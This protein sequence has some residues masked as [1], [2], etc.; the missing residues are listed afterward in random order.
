VP[1][2]PDPNKASFSVSEI[3]SK[4]LVTPN[5]CSAQVQQPSPGQFVIYAR[6]AHFMEK[7]KQ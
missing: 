1:C 7:M 5:D 2:F 3:M 4:G 6:P